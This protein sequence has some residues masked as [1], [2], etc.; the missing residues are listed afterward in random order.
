MRNIYIFLKNKLFHLI[1]NTSLILF[2]NFLK[3]SELNFLLDTKWQKRAAR[4]VS[5]CVCV[6]SSIAVF[7]YNAPVFDRR[8]FAA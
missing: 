1:T 8:D 3:H 4:Y 5:E 7:L 2:S 6:H